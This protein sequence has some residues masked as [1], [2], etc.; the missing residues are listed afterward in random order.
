MRRG[1]LL[2]ETLRLMS[3]PSCK[4]VGEGGCFTLITNSLRQI[5]MLCLVA[6][7]F[8]KVLYLSASLSLL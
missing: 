1:S 5:G 8:G 7:Q 3:F 6:V 2:D 4:L